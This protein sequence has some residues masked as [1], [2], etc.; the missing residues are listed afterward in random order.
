MPPR[1]P[2]FGGFDQ[3]STPAQLYQSDRY[4]GLI[5]S[6]SRLDLTTFKPTSISLG[7]QV[8]HIL[9][10]NIPD[11]MDLIKMCA[12]DILTML[13]KLQAYIQNVVPLR[14]GK[15]QDQLFQNS[16]MQ[17]SF[18]LNTVTLAVYFIPPNDRPVV[19]QNPAHNGGVGWAYTYNILNPQYVKAHIVK[20]TAKGAYYLLDDPT[21][22][23]NYLQE[24]NRYAATV[25]HNAMHNAL[26]KVKIKVHISSIETVSQRSIGMIQISKTTGLPKG[27]LPPGYRPKDILISFN[28]KSQDSLEVIVTDLQYNLTTTQILMI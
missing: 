15:L 12:V 27:G 4:E 5:T 25:L 6:A 3:A 9:L 19:I 2:I 13:P 21:A 20:A 8:A 7:Y 26:L 16:Y 10:D 14:S 17:L 22:A 18:G 23:P 28:R 1:S 11:L 24:L